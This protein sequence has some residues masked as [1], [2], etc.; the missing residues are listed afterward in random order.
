M[1]K[2]RGRK[3]KSPVLGLQVELE[4]ALEVPSSLDALLLLLGV[5]GGD[6]CGVGEGETEDLK[7]RRHSVRATGGKPVICAFYRRGGKK[8]T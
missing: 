6:T 5:G 8:L 7:N 3:R 1:S 4:E 2:A